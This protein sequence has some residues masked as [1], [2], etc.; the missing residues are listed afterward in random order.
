[1]SFYF[2]HKLVTAEPF[3]MCQVLIGFAPA[4]EKSRDLQ[5]HALYVEKLP[6][7]NLHSPHSPRIQNCVGCSSGHIC[8]ARAHLFFFVKDVMILI[9]MQARIK[10]KRRSTCCRFFF[11]LHY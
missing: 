7:I 6:T 2:I 8:E 4:T 9:V 11:L 3:E 1:M 10:Y 5:T